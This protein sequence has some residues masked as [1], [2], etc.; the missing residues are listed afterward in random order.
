MLSIVIAIKKLMAYIIQRCDDLR[1]CNMIHPFAVFFEWISKISFFAIFDSQ[2][3]LC[4]ND[5]VEGNVLFL[6]GSTN[7]HGGISVKSCFFL[8]KVRRAIMISFFIYL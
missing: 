2:K 5:R 1:A 4:Y 6:N 7:G 3:V 8:R